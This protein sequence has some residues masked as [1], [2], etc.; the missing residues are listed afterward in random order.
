MQFKTTWVVPELMYTIDS[1]VVC[2]GFKIILNGKINFPNGK[3]E[4]SDSN[5]GYNHHG[6]T[7]Q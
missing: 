3:N 2:D 6:G 7:A 4:G 5:Q 1:I